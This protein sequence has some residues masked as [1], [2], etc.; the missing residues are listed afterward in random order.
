MENEI[1]KRLR[2]FAENN[3]ELWD[4]SDLET[5]EVFAAELTLFIAENRKSFETFLTNEPMQRYGIHSIVY[6]IISSYNCDADLILFETSRLLNM[7]TGIDHQFGQLELLQDIDT[8]E[9]YELNK[10]VYVQF[11]DLII[12]A[13]ANENHE[14]RLIEL[15]HL[16]RLTYIY[17]DDLSERIYTKNN[18]INTLEELGNKSSLN[19][20][21]ALITLNENARL[22]LKIKPFTTAEKIRFEVSFIKRFFSELFS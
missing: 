18:W 8:L 10:T 11:I 17:P 1:I 16:F 2:T 7:F 14:K 22:N 12:L 20:R 3:C 15:L 4:D 9:L 21:K 5:S 13:I 19:V 6:E